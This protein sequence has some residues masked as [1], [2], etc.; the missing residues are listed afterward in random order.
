MQQLLFSTPQ[1]F[2]GNIL[3]S[4]Y[5][6]PD[7]TDEVRGRTELERRRDYIKLMEQETGDSHFNLLQMVKQCLHNAPRQRPSAEGVLTL[8]EEMLAE[9]HTENSF[10][11]DIERMR[12]ASEMKMRLTLE[13]KLTAEVNS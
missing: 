9:E 7:N 13:S 6:N 5:L 12:L 3:S 4:T 1:K 10:K 8:L 11:L 2:P